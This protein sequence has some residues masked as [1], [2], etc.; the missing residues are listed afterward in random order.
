MVIDNEIF[1]LLTR[2]RQGIN[3]SEKTMALDIIKKVGPNGTYIDIEHTIKELRT[4]EHWEPIVTNRESY[5]NWINMGSPAIEEIAKEKAEDILNTHA[6]EQL[7]SNIQ[8]EI[9]SIIKNFE[10]RLA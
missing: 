1:G 7:D 2:L 3:V 6:V 10:S 4:G 5:E 8:N 9:K